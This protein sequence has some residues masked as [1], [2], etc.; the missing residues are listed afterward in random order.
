MRGTMIRAASK[1]R[2]LTF[3][4]LASAAISVIAAL[5][6]DAE[7]SHSVGP[8]VLVGE[9]GVGQKQRAEILKVLY[10]GAKIIILDEPTAVLVPQEVDELFESLRELTASGATA[11]RARPFSRRARSM[12]VS[13]RGPRARRAS[14]PWS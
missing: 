8:D 3:A 1:S 14:A 2:A 9:L 13:G 10:R 7:R 12:H 11:K 4:F 6:D 5:A